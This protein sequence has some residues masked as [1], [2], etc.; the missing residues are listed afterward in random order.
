MTTPGNTSA[1]LQK[2]SPSPLVTKPCLKRTRSSSSPPRDMNFQYNGDVFTP[3]INYFTS[4][5]W[6]SIPKPEVVSD[7]TPIASTSTKRV[8]FSHETM[9]PDLKNQPLLPAPPPFNTDLNYESGCESDDE[10]FGEEEPTESVFGSPI[11]ISKK[12]KTV[13]H[14]EITIDDIDDEALDKPVPTPTFATTHPI[15]VSLLNESLISTNLVASPEP[16]EAEARTLSPEQA[17]PNFLLSVLFNN[18][19]TPEP[20]WITPPRHQ[21]DAR[22]KLPAR[23]AWQKFLYGDGSHS[24]D[25]EVVVQEPIEPTI[26]RKL[27]SEDIEGV[28][29]L[30]SS[31]LVK[32]T[33]G[34]D[35]VSSS[36]TLTEGET[37]TTVSNPAQPETDDALLAK[38]IV[39]EFGPN[40]VTP[41]ETAS[42][43]SDYISEILAIPTTDH[44]CI[45]KI[46]EPPRLPIAQ[47]LINVFRANV[48]TNAPFLHLTNVD[49]KAEDE[50]TIY[51]VYPPLP[52]SLPTQKEIESAS[53]DVSSNASD[54][55]EL[56]LFPHTTLATP[57]GSVAYRRKQKHA[58]ITMK[59]Y[60]ANLNKSIYHGREEVDWNAQTQFPST[61][62][63]ITSWAALKT[64]TTAVY[65][66][67]KVADTAVSATSYLSGNSTLLVDTR[68]TLFQKAKGL[69]GWVFGSETSIGG[70]K[71]VDSVLTTARS[72]VPRTIDHA[73]AKALDIDDAS[74]LEESS[75]YWKRLQRR[76]GGVTR[77]VG[78][79]LANFNMFYVISKQPVE[80]EEEEFKERDCG[81]VKEKSVVSFRNAPSFSFSSVA[82]PLDALYSVGVA[83][84]LLLQFREELFTSR[85]GFKWLGSGYGAIVAAVMALELGNDGLMSARGMFERI[86]L[87]SSNCLLGPLGNTSDFL[88]K[89]L[90]ALIPEDVSAANRDNLFISVSLLPTMTND[91]LNFYRSKESLIQSLLASCYVPILHDSPILLNNT[92]TFEPSYAIAG[93]F[94]NRLPIFNALTVTVSPIPAEANISPWCPT[95]SAINH[96]SGY[97]VFQQGAMK[98]NEVVGFFGSSMDLLCQESPAEESEQPITL[99]VAKERLKGKRDVGLWMDGLFQSGNVTVLAFKAML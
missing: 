8:S 81:E 75:G 92:S 21:K 72:I 50:T 48:T 78:A 87:K 36:I 53:S 76:T 33:N 12:A 14:R 43:E 77:F 70:N 18:G 23:S 59:A 80:N 66:A 40:Y 67:N 39:S 5:W 46:K 68:N 88:K 49:F 20:H 41:P 15:A 64:A 26:E 62:S 52:P 47:T 25:E 99:L 19:P 61:T 56:L 84:G 85:E 65:A 91:I 93:S 60:Q 89:E 71:V 31:L 29:K 45:S 34:E 4:N 11:K 37:A 7:P 6:W 55:S 57:K 79:T 73:L 22:K 16:S 38:L 27:T 97:A 54:I 17:N 24:T 82:G 98:D 83:E 90:E 1:T 95:L 32:S 51:G 10:D 30:V 3:S 69:A 42:S 58:E 63:S 96:N 9:N 86:H 74:N 13:R 94:T 2:Y 44:Q 28:E 35:S